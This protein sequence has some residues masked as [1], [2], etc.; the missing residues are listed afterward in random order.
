MR[1]KP[2]FA[3]GGF[4]RDLLLVAGGT[5]AAQA[6]LV[7]F[8]PL[9]ARLYG[10]EAFGIS[11]VFVS[12]VAIVSP[13][14]NLA[15][16]LAVALP[17]EDR[18]SVSLIYLC[19]YIGACFAAISS[20]IVIF[21]HRHIGHLIGLGNSSEL[22]L[23]APVAVFASATT[24][25]L[26][27]WLIRKREFG[28]LGKIS[29]LQAALANIMKVTAGLVHPGPGILVGVGVISS[30]VQTCYFWRASHRIIR[31]SVDDGSRSTTGASFRSVAYRY[32]EFPIYRAPQIWL[33]AVSF[34]LPVILLASLFGPSSAGFF[35]IGRSIL[36]LP[37]SLISRSV[38]TVFLPRLA[39]VAH[40]GESIQPLL[41]KGTVGLALAGLPPFC[42]VM[43]FG[44]DIFDLVLGA[45]WRR[46]GEY[47]RWLSLWLYMG[48]I[49][50]PTVQAIPI[51]G[52]QGHLLVYEGILSVMRTLALLAGAVLFA[53]DLTTVKFFS[54]TSATG[55]IWLV[56]WVLMRSRVSGGGRQFQDN[57]NEYGSTAAE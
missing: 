3:R 26:Q 42:L 37:A 15:Y 16:G 48:F 55:Y 35:A 20:V 5:A 25:P 19:F 8:S 39:E 54:F 49:N 6:I 1:G 9:I 21:S 36:G 18:Q 7:A 22:L 45:E 34:S 43:V 17:K 27:Q 29:V 44:P 40:R 4:L 56:G 14:A 33:N 31:R 51:L 2:N 47:A 52:L 32:R 46:A 24:I 23:F 41:I 12:F 10:P 57:D 28:T 50:V 38:G 13:I 30:V 11:G 53:N